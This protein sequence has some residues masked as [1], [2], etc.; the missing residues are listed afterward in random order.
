[1]LEENERQLAHKARHRKTEY[2]KVVENYKLHKMYHLVYSLLNKRELKNEEEKRVISRSILRS[3]MLE[4]K[5][6]E[7]L[8][9]LTNG[10]QTCGA[11][12]RRYADVNIHCIWCN[13][14][15]DTLEHRYFSCTF[16][17][18]VWEEYKKIACISG[19]LTDLYTKINEW[20]A[21]NA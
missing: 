19:S 13:S 14:A 5:V 1:M 9:K 6:K 4:N 18:P 17:T 20:K 21:L 16:L 15:V 7:L 3:D 8:W 11:E 2:D 10:G 12:L